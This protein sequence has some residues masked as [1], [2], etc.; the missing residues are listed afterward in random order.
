MKALLFEG[1]NRM[2]VR[3]VPTPGAPE[4]G[5]LVKVAACLICGTDIRIYRGKKTKDV[6]IPSILG[7][8]FSGVIAETGGKVDGF[9]AGDPVSVAPVLPCLTCYNCKHAQENVCLNRTAFGYEYDGAFAEYVA[10]PAAALRSGNVYPA[11]AGVDLQGVALAEPLACCI[12]GHG[13]SPV[14]LGDTVV[15]MGAG[16]IG[17]MH[18]L[19][20]KQSG[21]RVIVSE[22]S[23]ARRA[24]A[25]S[26][27]A[28]V[29]VDPTAQDLP[30]VVSENTHGVGADVVILAIG[31]PALVNQAIDITRKRGWVNLFAGFSVG[32]MPPVDVNKIHYRETRVT[33]TSASSRKDHEVAVKLIANRAVDPSKII[34]HRFPLSQAA[35]AFT[36][37]ETGAGIKVAVIP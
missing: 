11:P 21:A 34:T 22:P 16:P 13:N 28:D 12:N 1:P 8:E 26:L 27:G 31:V 24:T 6:R 18:M 5:L 19:L 23:A 37:A 32:D 9:R 10:I 33:G 2:E 30:M 25:L 15:V 36:A 20:A 14:K 7:H 29:A 4:G 17:L 35:E 3:E